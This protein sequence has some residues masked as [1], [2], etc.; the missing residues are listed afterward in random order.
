MKPPMTIKKDS[1][2]C[3]YCKGKNFEKRKMPRYKY[4]P[5]IKIG[6]LC[7]ECGETVVVD[8]YTFVEKY[9]IKAK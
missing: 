1:Y 2:H 7:L 3:R 8:Y 6:L 4:E 5:P 9:E